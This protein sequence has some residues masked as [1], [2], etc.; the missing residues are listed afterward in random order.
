MKPTSLISGKTGGIQFVCPYG[1]SIEALAF[2][3]P[4]Q[5]PSFKEKKF[6]CIFTI[7]SG[8]LL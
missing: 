8:M 4:F 2:I 7:F 3:Y 5:L 1:Q 6:L